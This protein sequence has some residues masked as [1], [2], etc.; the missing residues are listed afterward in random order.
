MK[1]CQQETHFVSETVPFHQES[2][3]FLGRP[4]LQTSMYFSSAKVRTH[5]SAPG[6]RKVCTQQGRLLPQTTLGSSQARGRVRI[7]EGTWRMCYILHLFPLENFLRQSYFLKTVFYSFIYFWLCWV[8][9][10]AQ[11][12]P[13]LR[14]VAATLQLRCTASHSGGFSCCR[15]WALEHRLNSCGIRAQLLCSMWDLSRSGLKPACPVLA[16]GFFTTEQ[17][18]GLAC[19]DSWGHKES[20]TTE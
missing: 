5:G 13:Q 15:A 18:G 1:E 19:C 16:G 3:S 7:A 10:A 6:C 20:D 9:V 2:S 12:F 11:A 8:F 14:R 17:Q 4:S